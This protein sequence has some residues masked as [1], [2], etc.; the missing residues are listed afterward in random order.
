[1]SSALVLSGVAVLVILA[2]SRRAAA[3]P[4]LHVTKFTHAQLIELARDVG[5][6]DPDYAATIAVRESGGDPRAVNDTRGVKNLPEGHLPE[7]SCG[8]WQI[9]VLAHKQHTCEELLD[10][11]RNAE[12]ALEIR[13]QSGWKPWST[14]KD[15]L[16]PDPHVPGAT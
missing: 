6:P 7:H 5:F 8:L 2:T 15:R 12:A 4:P 3:A 10:P 1:M 9:N 16:R 11:R 14:A 13:L